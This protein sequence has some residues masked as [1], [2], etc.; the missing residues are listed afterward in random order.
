MNTFV[1]EK[2]KTDY[3]NEAIA[4]EHLWLEEGA[5]FKKLAELFKNNLNKAPSELISLEVNL[6]SYTKIK[7]RLNSLEPEL[8]ISMFGMSNYPNRLRDAT[9]PVE[10]LY[11]L[12][13]WKLINNK[14]V[15]VVGSRKVSE[16]GIRRTKRL[17]KML[18][19][20]GYT[21]ISGLA[22]GVD[23]AAH[24]TAIE[25]GGKTIAVI[26]T[27]LDQN[28]PKKNADLQ[29]FIAKEHLL[30]SQVP[31][32]RYSRQTFRTNRFFFPERNATMSALSEATIII[33]AGETSGTL[34]QARAATNQG[35]KLFILENNFNKSELSWPNN[36][37]KKGALR[38]KD[39]DDFLRNM[40]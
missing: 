27:P 8:G 17:V 31:F 32:E 10:L 18:V 26:G 29:K 5:S 7:T 11:Y 38:L 34:V 6:E 33:E 2:D 25:M 30:I 14:I 39:Y 13:D 19:K 28:Y 36:Y 21:I 24:E 23:T 20:D 16:E 35:R 9:N 15:S 37:L 12:G 4:Y 40:I 1:V 22:E 3:I